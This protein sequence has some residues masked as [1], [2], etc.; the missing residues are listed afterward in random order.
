MSPH[1]PQI[2][3]TARSVRGGAAADLVGSSLPDVNEPAPLVSLTD[4]TEI[5]LLILR[6]MR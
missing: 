1:T 4:I 6:R 2:A 3:G 5:E